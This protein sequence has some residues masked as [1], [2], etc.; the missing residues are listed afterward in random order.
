VNG[1]ACADFHD[2]M[3][4][5]GHLGLQIHGGVSEGVDKETGKPLQVRWRNM[6]IQESR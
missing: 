5:R 1:I 3:D 4:L 2:S 6:R